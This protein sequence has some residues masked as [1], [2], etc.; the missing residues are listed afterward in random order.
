MMKNWMR[1]LTSMV[2][3]LGMVAGCLVFTP[4]TVRAASA[5][6]HEYSD[7]I[8]QGGYIYYIKESESDRP[9]SIWRM[10]VATGETE[11]VL[12]EK[13]GICKLT[14]SG[15]QLYY[16]TSNESGNWETRTCPL[17]GGTAETVCEGFA[18]YADIQN[19]YFTRIT[20]AKIY[21]YVKNLES[22]E[23]TLLRTTKKDQTLDYA[24]NIGG[25]SYYYLYDRS[26]EK[27]YLYCLNT[28]SENKKLIRVASEK[29]VVK[30]T[31]GALQVTDIKQINGELYYNFGSYEG[32]GNFW[33]GTIK[34]LT[35]DGAKK[36]VAKYSGDQLIKAGR[37]ELYF[38]DLKG[39]DY[40]YNLKTGKKT[41]YSLKF[42]KNI[43]YTV[44]GD[45][46]WMIDTSNKNKIVISRFASG[47]DRET[48]TKNFISIPF[49]QKTGISYAVSVKQIG[50][51]NMI[52]VTGT[53]F[54]P[55]YGWRGKKVSIDWF[56]TD[57]GAGTLL[58]SFK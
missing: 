45:K 42:E 2:F 11:K 53:D 6:V 14:V 52:C 13:Q 5:Y 34:K 20:D 54:D 58:G 56:V 49:K 25:D 37:R 27:L 35:V 9:A 29:R 1:Y 32:S 55:A 46:T 19:V 17:S 22:G 12:T 43:S 30:D 40:K 16:V 41:K 44:L 38:W 26:S 47:T 31:V 3:V 28:T 50:V 8:G 36:T 51:Y 15:K 24:C 4:D 23:E 21:L 10:K 48:L 7:M 39:N 57:A 18:C 33:N